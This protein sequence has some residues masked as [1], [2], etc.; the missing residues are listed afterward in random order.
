MRTVSRLKSQHAND[1][2]AGEGSGLA[3]FDSGA[4]SI[5]VADEHGH[6]IYVNQA[7]VWS[8]IH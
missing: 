2:F 4:V 7:A 8:P 1:S 5:M 6:L 3:A